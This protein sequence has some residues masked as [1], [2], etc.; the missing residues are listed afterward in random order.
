MKKYDEYDWNVI[1]TEPINDG[2]NE[3]AIFKLLDEKVK[4]D[5]KQND[6]NKGH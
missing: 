2:E 6:D 5:E 4:N 3:L 1:N